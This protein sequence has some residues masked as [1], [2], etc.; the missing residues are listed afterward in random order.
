MKYKVGEDGDEAM[1]QYRMCVLFL[2]P[3]S[4]HFYP[5]FS[6][7][8]FTSNLIFVCI[9]MFAD[10]MSGLDSILLYLNSL[11]HAFALRNRSNCYGFLN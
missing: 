3:P 2:F 1:T 10:L 4:S 8:A 7:F 6:Y 11:Y 5:P 9:W